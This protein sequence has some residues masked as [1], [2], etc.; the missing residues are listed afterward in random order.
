MVEW[1]ERLNTAMDYIEEHLCEEIKYEQLAKLACCSAYHFQRMFGY[2]AGVTLSAYIR[3]RRMSCAAVD[4][5]KGY[6]VIDVA[7]A[8]GYESPTAFNRA[9]QAVCGV[10][11]SNA[12]QSG[13]TLKSFLPISFKVTIKGVEEMNY[14]I[15]SKPE[16]RVIGIRK[17]MSADAEEGFKVVPL[18]WQDAAAQIP[19]IASYM[20]GLDG[21][22]GLDGMSGNLDGNPDDTPKGLLGVSTCNEV[23][24]E[25]NY[26]Y[27]AVAS[28]APIPDGMHELSI[29]AQTWAIFPGS[30]TST[31]I[32]TLQQRIVSEWLP[33]SGYEW[34]NAPDIELYL[35]SDPENMA[36]EV[37]LPVIDLKRT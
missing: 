23:D 4:L 24:G 2:M 8:Y 29:P 18:F 16:F 17:A 1:I 26:Y 11:P 25:Q 14:R 31:D 3:R 9:F 13:V 36:F 37:W 10:A 22:D 5:Q 30:G 35:N 32:Q 20:G 33:T 7:L 34:A 27:I 19:Q 21:M 15:E 6:K 28:N 12:K